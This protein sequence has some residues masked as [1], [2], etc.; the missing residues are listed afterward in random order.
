[1]YT[2]RLDAT[3]LCTPRVND[4]P[5]P[6]PPIPPRYHHT[7]YTYHRLLSAPCSS[8][9]I[10]Q[11]HNHDP[12]N[13]PAAQLL[14]AHRRNTREQEEE[15]KPLFFRPLAITASALLLH[16]VREVCAHV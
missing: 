16:G 3:P 7:F 8:L 1:M 6:S 2:E 12:N 11:P 9:A 15:K 13:P 4:R 5:I 14:P 10:L